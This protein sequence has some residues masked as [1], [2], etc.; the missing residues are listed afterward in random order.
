[1]ADELNDVL[2]AEVEH[3]CHILKNHGLGLKNLEEP[4]GVAVEHIPRVIEECP[5]TLGNRVE[6]GTADS[7]KALTWRASNEDIN[8]FAK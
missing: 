3:S 7:G 2:S 4:N 8:V 6:P 1:M 5:R